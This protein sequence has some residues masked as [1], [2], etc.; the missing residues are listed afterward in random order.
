MLT[1]SSLARLRAYEHFVDVGNVQVWSD[2]GTGQ[3]AR[4]RSI[5]TACPPPL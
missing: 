4:F 5:P 1:L 3:S 2:P